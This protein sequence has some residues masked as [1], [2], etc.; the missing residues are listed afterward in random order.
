MGTRDSI[1]IV[2][3]DKNYAEKSDT[4]SMGDKHP[5]DY[6]SLADI[7]L[8]AESHTTCDEVVLL[9]YSD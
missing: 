8:S 5:A 1:E 9:N 7:H 2:G 6:L 3:K 4:R